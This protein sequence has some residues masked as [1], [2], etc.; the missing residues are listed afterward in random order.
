MNDITTLRRLFKDFDNN[1]R[2]YEKNRNFSNFLKTI[3]TPTVGLLFSLMIASLFIYCVNAY[4]EV[5]PGID[6]KGLGLA[7]FLILIGFTCFIHV[8]LSVG[9]AQFKYALF[10]YFTFV[11]KG[12]YKKMSDSY[13]K[14]LEFEYLEER[15]RLIK[16]FEYLDVLDFDYRKES[17]ELKDFVYERLEF[18]I[19]EQKM[20]EM[21]KELE[22][23]HKN[24]NKSS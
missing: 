22:L 7:L 5:I 8:L 13:L 4:Y 16:E 19:K 23:L 2:E 9:C 20:K 17:Q 15:S 24:I 12:N 6:L 18:R 14:I 11:Y 3:F 1:E 10:P 21:K